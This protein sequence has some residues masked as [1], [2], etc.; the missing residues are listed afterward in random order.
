MNHTQRFGDPGDID[1]KFG[2]AL[3]ITFDKK[4]NDFPCDFFQSF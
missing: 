2:S 3:A 4:V 1:L